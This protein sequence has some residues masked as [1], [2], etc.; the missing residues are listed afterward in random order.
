MAI[1]AALLG[2]SRPCHGRHTQHQFSLSCNAKVPDSKTGTVSN[3][4]TADHQTLQMQ[5]HLL[6]K[7]QS[8]P[9]RA[10]KATKNDQAWQT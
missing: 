7:E 6:N 2:E 5:Q 4:Y 3:A 10:Y 9:S 1:A 8:G